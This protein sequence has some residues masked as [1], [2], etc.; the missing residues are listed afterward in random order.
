MLNSRSCENN[1][2]ERQKNQNDCTAANFAIR[3]SHGIEYAYSGYFIIIK[4]FKL[5]EQYIHEFFQRKTFKSVCNEC[6]WVRTTPEPVSRHVKTWIPHSIF[7][8]G[9]LGKCIF[10][11]CHAFSKDYP[12]IRVTNLNEF[13]ENPYYPS[14]SRNCRVMDSEHC[15]CGFI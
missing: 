8:S 6:S 13:K 14:V 15:A 2:F 3:T 5:V 10:F 4:H 12:C 9:T 1:P 7:D 11:I